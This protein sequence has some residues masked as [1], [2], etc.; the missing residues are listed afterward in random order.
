MVLHI[1]G[2]L[3]VLIWLRI[4]EISK[5]TGSILSCVAFKEDRN[6]FQGGDENVFCALPLVNSFFLARMKCQLSMDQGTWVLGEYMFL[7]AVK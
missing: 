2:T 1:S 4:K 3:K 7:L 5:G 6:L